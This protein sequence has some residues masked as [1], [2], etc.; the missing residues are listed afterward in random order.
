MLFS[1]RYS[2]F[3]LLVILAVAT[4]AYRINMHSTSPT[5]IQ[6]PND[7]REYRSL[8]LDNG[9][10]VILVSD[11]EADK[12]AA[13]LAVS[14]GSGDDPQG[15]QG[16]AHFLEHMLFLGTE[17]FPDSGEYQDYI[18]K[19]GGSHNAFTAHDVTNYFFE[20]DNNDLAGAL[21]RFAPFFISPTFDANY[22]EREKNAVNAEYTSKS[23]DDGRR[24]FSAEKQAMN[25]A[26][27]YAK[28][29]TGSLTTLEDRPGSAI[30][31]ELITFYNQ[32]YSA[33]E[34]TF[35]L[36]GNYDLDTLEQWTQ[37]R[38]SAIPKRDIVV[39][40][41]RP[42][43]YQ[44]DQL[45]LDLQI[46]PIKELRQLKLAFPMPESLSLYQHKPLH[47]I[48]HLLGH[49]GEGSLLALF[50]KRGWA[51]GLSA[52]QGVST[53]WESTLSINIQLTLVGLFRIDEITE[54]VFAYIELVQ[55]GLQDTVFIERLYA[56][57]RQ[58]ADL[59]FA[60]QEKSK[61]SHFAVRLTNSL[62]H[63]TPSQVIYGDY[64]WQTPTTDILKPYLNQLT[65]K[66]LIRTLIAP[67]VETNTTDP[68]Y[69]T[70]MMLR[71]AVIK[72]E[73]ANKDPILKPEYREQLFLPAANPFIPES[74]T[75]TNAPAQ[76]I[77]TRLIDETGLRLWYYPEQEF[78]L[79]K[80]KVFINL[81]NQAVAD[82]AKDRIIAQLFSHSVNELISSYTYPAYVAGL[83]YQLHASGRGLE[84]SMSGYHDKLSVLLEKIVETM[85]SLTAENV[86]QAEFERYQAQLKRR[87]ENQLK[88]KP[89][90][91]TISELRRWLRNPSF[92]QQELIA[93]LE[94][95]T[96]DDV[97]AFNERLKQSLFVDS[98]VHGTLE[99]EAAIA[100]SK[101][102]E[103]AYKPSGERIAPAMISK[104]PNA[105]ASANSGDQSSHNQSPDNQYLQSIEQQHP[106]SA[107]SLYIQGQQFDELT[108]DNAR[109]HYALLAQI[110]ST[111]Y[112]QW[113][114]TEKKMGYIVSASPFPQ[115][116]VPGMIFIV[117]SP[118]ASS[119]DILAESEL[120]FAD[121]KQQL[122]QLSAKEFDDHKQGLISRLV[123]KKKNM[124]EKV[125]HFWHNI[126]V[127][128]LTFDTNEAIAKEV[129]NIQLKDIQGLFEN[130]I[131]EKKDPRLLFSHSQQVP[132][133]GWAELSSI[134]KNDLDTL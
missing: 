7:Q 95:V 16:L 118:T 107:M 22:V 12:A 13:S 132:T 93:A 63:R 3:L 87:L 94:T 96:L 103:Q 41:K 119:A 26:H 112:Y 37:E 127:N 72:T 129:A 86:S 43:L 54:A 111:P 4:A 8:E 5:I 70:K 23:K 106:D 33:N 104:V 25:P 29:A 57:Q 35:A 24:I 49:E 9:L 62:R 46:E 92:S 34:M 114:R 18:S 85:A 21:D 2:T 53:P 125:G 36:I 19:H 100:I 89:Y 84:L 97:L 128:R 69:D 38:F 20:I 79:P 133:D 102:L 48:N 90:E 58:L 83:N 126:E 121:F 88:A 123:S 10:K 101:V 1:T 66:N 134:N 61:A 45:P 39:K 77:P 68:W 59:A 15:R 109:A 44:Q 56:E 80:A 116:A 78:R 115:N 50:K 76:T 55:Q 130:S 11:K 131:I 6:S 74:F 27:P 122:A 91:R 98:Y 30:R 120:F 71:P 99:P 52:G 82:N 42:P 28:F 14:V 110:I 75:L 105:Q 31:D 67:E 32:H 65:R 47:I 51:E 40:A 81:H 117:Q 108:S 124:A 17:P 113:L 60:N 64:D 73:A